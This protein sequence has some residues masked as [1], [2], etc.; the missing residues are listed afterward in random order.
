M[1]PDHKI[2]IVEDEMVISMELAHT[3]RRLGYGIAGQVTRGEDAIEMTGKIRPDLVL[4]DIILQGEIDGI[5]AA[6][7]IRELYNIPVVFLTAH[8]DEATLQRA[9]AVQPSGY[10]IKPF[11]DRE[12]YST[13]E[14]SLH[15]YDIRRRIMPHVLHH[16][17]EYGVPDDI[18]CLFLST[19]W[20]ITGGTT[21]AF[22][23]LGMSPGSLIQT[24]FDQLIDHTSCGRSVIMP[25]SISVRTGN[26]LCIPVTLGL[27]A[28]TG[29]G[30]TIT[31]YLLT[32]TRRDIPA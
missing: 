21:K 30:G 20:I 15:K 5:E 9:I 23:M 1:N 16:D 26:G 14:L 19:D 27:G 29:D 12:L 3:L 17:L 7:R 11:R 32:L 28:V 10:L 6:D 8:S 13:I 25:E 4:M 22:N 24:R 31:G 18:P 2:L